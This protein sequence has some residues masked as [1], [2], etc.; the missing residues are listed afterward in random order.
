M[1]LRS[2][3]LS[4]DQAGQPHALNVRWFEK[5]NLGKEGMYITKRNARS[6][7]T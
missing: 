3:A 2:I 5:K 1:I 4:K 6:K 7:R